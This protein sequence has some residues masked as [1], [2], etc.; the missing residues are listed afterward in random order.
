MFGAIIPQ[1]LAIPPRVKVEPR[2]NA[3]FWTWSVVRIPL[4]ASSPPETDSFFAS[5]GVAARILSIGK[6]VP[7]IPVEQTSTSLASI[8]SARAAASAIASA[9]AM[10]SAPVPALA[11]PELTMIAAARPPFSARRLRSRITGGAANLFWVKTAT[12]VTGL[13]SSVATRAMS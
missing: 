2:T 7:M 5:F 6:G 9:S 1:P 3:S 13:R 11:L 10:P 4:A 8:P 12:A